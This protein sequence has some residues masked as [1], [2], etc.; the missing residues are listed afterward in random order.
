MEDISINQNKNKIRKTFISSIFIIIIVYSFPL[1]GMPIKPGLDPSWMFAINYLPKGYTWGSEINF[2]YGPLGFLGYPQDIGNNFVIAQIFWML[3]FIINLIGIIYL[4]QKNQKEG[5]LLSISLAALLF[6][7]STK[8]FERPEYYLIYIVILYVSIAWFCSER[9][10]IPWIIANIIFCISFYF[11]LSA[12]IILG[13]IL[14]LFI[15]SFIIKRQNVIP[16]ALIFI[17]SNFLILVSV[18]IYTGSIS[19]M[20]KYIKGSLDLSNGY[21]I[22]LSVSY[23][24][25]LVP[26]A[27]G[28]MLLYLILLAFFYKFN[29]DTSLYFFMFIGCIFFVFKHGF[30]RADHSHT[31]T[32]FSFLAL[33][34]SIQILFSNSNILKKAVKSTKLL[35][36]Y[37]TFLI[38]V[39]ASFIVLFS[40]SDSFG[41][42]DFNYIKNKPTGIIKFLDKPVTIQTENMVLDPRITEKIKNDTITIFPWE[43]SYAAYND[44]NYVPLP[45]F[46]THSAYTPY[47]DNLNAEFLS[48]SD[49][50]EYILFQFMAIDGRHPLI[51]VPKTWQTINDNYEAEMVYYDVALLKKTNK[52]YQAEY[53][54]LK[55]ETVN[56]G[57]II[58]IPSSE[59]LIISK[60]NMELSF[61]GK[62]TKFFYKIPDVYISYIGDRGLTCKYRIIPEN[63]GNGVII[64]NI[65]EGLIDTLA[66]LNSGFSYQ[67]VEKIKLSGPGLKYY[68]DEIEIEFSKL[69]D[70]ETLNPRGFEG[71]YLSKEVKTIYIDKISGNADGSIDYIGRSKL[72]PEFIQITG[73]GNVSGETS[74]HQKVYIEIYGESSQTKNY[75][76]AK[77]TMRP[78]VSQYFHSQNYDK[79]GYEFQINPVFMVNG[80]KYYGRVILENNG[81]YY[82]IGEVQELKLQN[83]ELKKDYSKEVGFIEAEPSENIKGNLDVAKINN[84]DFNEEINVLG[85]AFLEN[86]DVSRQDIFLQV[87]DDSGTIRFYPTNKMERGDVGQY[88]QDSKLNQTGF[89]CDIDYN[90]YAGVP[91]KIN[92]IVKYD[93]KFLMLENDFIINDQNTG[94]EGK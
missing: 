90:T 32:F 41:L 39:T 45:I 42:M 83:L 25:V 55:K 6:L 21:N 43:I 19:N 64:N 28:F 52:K 56:K 54:L 36:Y 93:D 57:Q 88:F 35:K 46:Q 70:K 24:N 10:I 84:Y 37:N 67:N 74:D 92:I 2:P 9:K 77:Q 27:I 68:K 16:F 31:V 51:D 17:I 86:E 1:Y 59:D 62:L 3:L 20:V 80:E 7:V 53:D 48:S 65:P 69:L 79:S 50:P 26:I 85:W 81:K 73:W 12:A 13:S 8:V 75:Y 66:M 22:A 34:F 44:I 4:I 78:D 82:T 15:I 91:Y 23:F 61:W 14:L 33:L 49:A 58:K 76:L 72:Y 94:E 89:S 30:V 18:L 5:S 71:D 29:K 40:V 38:I 47:L 63:L 60:I 11:K 87:T